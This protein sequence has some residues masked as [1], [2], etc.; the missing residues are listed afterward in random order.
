VTNPH[1]AQLIFTTHDT[2]LLNIKKLRRDQIWFIE[3][4]RFAASTLYSLVEFK[5]RNDDAS[6]EQDYIR[7]RYG[8]VP[9]IGEL[10]AAYQDDAP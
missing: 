9:Y 2:N 7:G 8:A 1:G 10:Q 3:K 4:D 5:I 6:L